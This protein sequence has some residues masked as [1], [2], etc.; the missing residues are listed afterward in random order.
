MTQPS[1]PIQTKGKQQRRKPSKFTGKRRVMLFGFYCDREAVARITR[2][3]IMA[4]MF[5]L[6]FIGSQ[7]WPCM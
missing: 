3:H 6:V 1:D 5:S 7:G 4:W 2:Q